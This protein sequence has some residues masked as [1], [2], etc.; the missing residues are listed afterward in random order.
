MHLSMI[1]LSVMKTLK[2]CIKREVLYAISVHMSITFVLYV[3][4]ICYYNALC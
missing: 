4:L 3:H 2:I 1:S